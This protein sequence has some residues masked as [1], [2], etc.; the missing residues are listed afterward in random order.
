LLD[1]FVARFNAREPAGIPAQMLEDVT[2][3]IK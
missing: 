2:V 1:R 3:E